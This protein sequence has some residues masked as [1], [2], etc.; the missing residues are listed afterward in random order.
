L[1]WAAQ[2]ECAQKGTEMAENESILTNPATKEDAVH[3]RDY[4]R[5]TKLFTIGAA[6]C[7]VLAMI[8]L[9]IL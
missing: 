8:I 2:A 7:F 9:A 6:V 1:L 5:F 3:V 4:V